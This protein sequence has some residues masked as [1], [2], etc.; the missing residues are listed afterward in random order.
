MYYYDSYLSNLIGKYKITNV[1]SKVVNFPR[2]KGKGMCEGWDWHITEVRKNILTSIEGL[3][4]TIANVPCFIKKHSET[5][6]CRLF[7]IKITNIR[8]LKHLVSITYRL[9]LQTK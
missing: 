1:K 9:R 7:L 5:L 3:R 8:N 2:L 4:L 6:F